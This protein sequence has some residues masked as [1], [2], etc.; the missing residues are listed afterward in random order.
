MY[1]MI[2]VR[3][4]RPLSEVEAATEAHRAYLRTLAERG[5]LVA[6]GPLD[7]RFG[8]L[9]LVRV[10][11]ENPLAD[12]DALMAG[13]PFHQQGLA[14]YELLPWKVLQGKEGLDRI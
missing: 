1:A 11:D 3:Y 7:P 10:Q 9:W 13:D 2:I 8:G 5:T 14:N 4:R 12:L 6:S